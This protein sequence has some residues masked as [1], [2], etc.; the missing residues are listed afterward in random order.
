MSLLE[1]HGKLRLYVFHILLFFFSCGQK[2]LS[3]GS[4]SSESIYDPLDSVE[5]MHA[6][7]ILD[8]A[9]VPHYLI[10]VNIHFVNHPEF[11]TFSRAPVLENQ[12]L[13]GRYWA[14]L[15]INHANWALDSLNDSPISLQSMK[16]DAH[17]NYNIY[18]D[19]GNPNDSF[20]GIWFWDKWAPAQF[21]YGDRVLNIV[22]Q[23]DGKRMLNGSACGLNFCNSLIMYGAFYNA[24]YQGKFGWWSF[25][26]LLNHEVGHIFG[27]CHSF[28]CE[29]ECA[30]VDLDPAKECYSGPCYN[31][32]G[33]P[34][35]G[36]CNNWLANS[37]NMMG[38]NANQNA[39]TPC[40]WKR[41]MIN[42]YNSR[43]QY[44]QRSPPLKTPKTSD[45]KK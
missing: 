18:T 12:I 3:G 2:F 20:G 32:C 25:A 28:T 39:L 26:S 31:D 10:D 40:Q 4:G 22:I 43:A 21:P 8:T 17:Y 11:G 36:Q 35:N 5:I 33:G 9:N 24:K 44:I 30:G 37:N 14:E 23:D 15:L 41:I 29:N 13:H 38:Y 6:I 16:G 1:T 42:L 34:N 27:L 7:Q 19:K 45:L